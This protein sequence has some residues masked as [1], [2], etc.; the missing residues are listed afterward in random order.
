MATKLRGFLLQSTEDGDFHDWLYAINPLLAG[1]MRSVSWC[2]VYNVN[3][4]LWSHCEV[5][6]EVEGVYSS[7]WETHLRATGR[8]LSYGVI[9]H[10]WTSPVLTPTKQADFLPGGM[11]G[12]VDLGG[13]LHTEMVTDASTG[14]NVTQ[15]RAPKLVTAKPCYHQVYPQTLRL[16]TTFTPDIFLAL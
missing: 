15:W 3:V 5:S 7:E 10:K 2:L 13:W 12:W 8:H 6:I 16:S 9:C 14:S 4:R 1:Q 11:E